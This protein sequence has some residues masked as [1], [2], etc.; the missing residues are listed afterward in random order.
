LSSIFENNRIAIDLSGGLDTSIVIGIIKHIGFDSFLVCMSSSRHE[1]RTES[2]IL[3]K[4]AEL[5][6]NVCLL[7]VKDSLPYSNLKSIPLHQDPSSFSLY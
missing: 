2:F 4:Y 5:F 3:D 1:L 6:K 7:N